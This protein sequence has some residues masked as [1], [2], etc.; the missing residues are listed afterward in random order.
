[1][2]DFKVAAEIEKFALI[3]AQILAD[4]LKSE[5]YQNTTRFN[6]RKFWAAYK[7][8]LPIHYHTYLAEVGCKKAASD[9]VESVFSG[10]GKFTA[11]APLV[12]ALTLSRIVKLPRRTRWTRRTRRTPRTR[13]TRRTR[14]TWRTRRTRR[15]QNPEWRRSRTVLTPVSVLV[16]DRANSGFGASVRHISCL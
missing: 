14:R 12:G 2:V 6:L 10:A 11:E 3:R 8:V 13:Q 9:N 7:L 5:Y 4:G 15:I 1:M 16:L